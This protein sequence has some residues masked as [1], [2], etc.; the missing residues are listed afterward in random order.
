MRDE[1]HT[2]TLSASFS[3]LYR[4]AIKTFRQE[5]LNFEI[6]FQ[7]ILRKSLCN[8]AINISGDIKYST[9]KSFKISLLHKTSSEVYQKFF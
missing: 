8:F 9:R 6:S 1:S 7:N 5:L 4:R 3:S 2:Y